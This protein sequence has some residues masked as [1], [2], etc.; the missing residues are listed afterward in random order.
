M[1]VVFDASTLVSAALKADSLPERALLR[2]I[3]NPHR[4]IVSQEVESDIEKSCCAR[5]S[6]ASSRPIAAGASWTS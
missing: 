2:A 3:G 1:I 4:L 5:S 6:T